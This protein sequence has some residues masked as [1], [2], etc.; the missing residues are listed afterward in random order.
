MEQY[1]LKN[2]FNAG[3]YFFSLILQSVSFTGI[4]IWKQS[5][6]KQRFNQIGKTYAGLNFFCKTVKRNKYEVIQNPLIDSDSQN[7]SC[8]DVFWFDCDQLKSSVVPIF[9]PSNLLACKLCRM[10]GYA[11]ARLLLATLQIFIKQLIT[12]LVRSRAFLHKHLWDWIILISR[13]DE[14]TQLYLW[15]PFIVGMPPGGAWPTAQKKP[16]MLKSTYF[17]CR[18][19]IMQEI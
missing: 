16:F 4:R 3:L 14:K 7:T 1:H 15:A 8:F 5:S 11:I 12:W 17:S 9:H 13:G 2:H 19:L 10:L 18:I 6:S